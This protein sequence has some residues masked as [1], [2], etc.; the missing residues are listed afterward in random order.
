M[1]GRKPTEPTP[2]EVLARAEGDAV[3]QRPADDDL[4]IV[5]RLVVEV[6]SDGKRTIARGAVEDAISGERTAIEARGASPAQ[7]AFALARSLWSLASPVGRSVGRL[8][9]PTRL[10]LRVRGLLGGRGGKKPDR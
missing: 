1:A 8:R 9:A 4:P 6:R 10:S 3:E 7:L 2:A 5:A